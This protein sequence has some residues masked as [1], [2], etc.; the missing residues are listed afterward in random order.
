MKTIRLTGKYVHSLMKPRNKDSHKGDYG[1]VLIIAGSRGMPG[2]PV[3]CAGGALRCGAGLVTVAVPEGQ[4]EIIAKRIR[5]EGML[6]PLPETSEGRI[7]VSALLKINEFIEKRK[8]SAIVIGPGMGAGLDTKK[9]ILKLISSFS[10]PV[11][12]DA[13]G[14]NSLSGVA[15]F[16]KSTKAQIILTPHPGEFGRLTGITASEIRHNRAGKAKEFAYGH[17]LVCVLKGDGTVVTDGKKVYMNA[18]GNPG[19]ASGG[20]GDVLAGMIGALAS[21]VKEPRVLNAAAAGV[22]IHGLAGDMA[23]RNKT[24]TGMLAGDIS[25]QIPK[26]LKRVSSKL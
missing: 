20:S 23:A 15:G 21:Q 4:Y 22:Y 25:E 17:G 16:L 5:P 1:H 9:L 6:L 26:A 14:L 8:I 3:L 12:I 11:V 7:S 10:I 2:A 18:T 24:M 13:D 19:M